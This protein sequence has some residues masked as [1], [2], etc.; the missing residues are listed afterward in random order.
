MTPSDPFAR[1]SASAQRRIATV[2]LLA[3]L[4]LTA[5]LASFDAHLRTDAAPKGIVSF[6]LAGSMDA[7]QKILNSWD[8]SARTYAGLSL[9]LD[10]AYPLAYATV[11]AYLCAWAARRGA[12]VWRTLG[13]WLCWGQWIAALADMV[14]NVGLIKLLVGAP[15]GAWPELA[16]SCATAKFALIGAGALY[17][18]GG[19][20]VRARSRP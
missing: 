1:L 3:T 20:F 17:S 13:L 15:S 10:F 19:A 5:A 9:G 18:L 12:G 11:L 14:E 4:A 7:A 16:A 8:A 2:A 6:E